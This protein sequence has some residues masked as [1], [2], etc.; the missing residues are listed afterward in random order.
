MNRAQHK[1]KACEEKSWH[2]R[3]SIEIWFDSFFIFY[4]S[5]DRRHRTVRS[6]S[7]FLNSFDL[8]SRE[9]RRLFTVTEKNSLQ[10]RSNVLHNF[11]ALVLCSHRARTSFL[12]SE[13]VREEFARRLQILEQCLVANRRA[14]WML[15]RTVKFNLDWKLENTKLSLLLIFFFHFRSQ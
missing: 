10:E 11:F 7:I 6:Y 2:G 1:S 15:M 4:S 13:Y 5:I 3:S 14:L 12:R 9:R 8:M